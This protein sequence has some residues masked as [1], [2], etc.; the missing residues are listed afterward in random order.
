MIKVRPIYFWSHKVLPLVYDDALSYYEVLNKVIGRFNEMAELVNQMGDAITLLDPDKVET[1]L[2]DIRTS[3]VDLTERVEAGEDKVEDIESRLA[4]V[5]EDSSFLL[6]WVTNLSNNHNALVTRMYTAEG[7]INTLEGKVSTIEG[8]ISTLQSDVSNLISRMTS[9]EGNIASQGSRLSTAEAGLSE[10]NTRLNNQLT[11]INGVIYDVQA[12][13][14]Q[15][16]S[17]AFIPASGGIRVQMDNASAIALADANLGRPVAVVNSGT[18]T[19][20]DASDAVAWIAEVLAAKA[21]G[22]IIQIY[23]PDYAYITEVCYYKHS[24]SWIELNF[25]RPAFE[26]LN[27]HY[28]YNMGYFIDVNATDPANVSYKVTTT[29]CATRFAT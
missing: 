27:Y 24:D 13:Q 22:K 4:Q 16:P 12:L 8:N 29:A 11:M 28:D 6:E 10:A 18:L 20:G 7:K 17:V 26:D 15:T 1:K 19:G 5:E 23:S 25:S 2:E 14:A 21:N 9:A 3:I